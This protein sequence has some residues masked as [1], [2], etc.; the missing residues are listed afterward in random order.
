MQLV[1]I[2]QGKSELYKELQNPQ[3]YEE[4]QPLRLE[5][6]MKKLNLAEQGII[7]EES[8]DQDVET[9]TGLKSRAALRSL[10]KISQHFD[11]ISPVV[12]TTPE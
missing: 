9:Y 6:L 3:Y 10:Y 2:A 5:R 11:T 1:R 7:D 8:I 12:E 4:F